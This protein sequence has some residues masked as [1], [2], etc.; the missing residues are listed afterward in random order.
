MSYDDMPKN[1]NTNPDK[2]LNL[3]IREDDKRESI[4]IKIQKC[5]SDINFDIEMYSKV[6]EML[7]NCSSFD[8][9]IFKLLFEDDEYKTIIEIAYLSNRTERQIKRIKKKFFDYMLDNKE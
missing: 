6:T 2:I 9:Y 8:R 7:S 1:P 5:I 3:L 4:D